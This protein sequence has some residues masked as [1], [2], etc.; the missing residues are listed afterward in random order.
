MP[1]IV[2]PKTDTTPCWW[3]ARPSS[4]WARSATIRA[5]GRTLLPKVWAAIDDLH[6]NTLEIPIYW[7]Q[8]EPEPGKF[9]TSIVD[10]I[11]KQAREHNVRLVLLWF[12]T[13]KNG[14]GHYIPLWAKK[15]AGD[16]H[17]H[18]GQSRTHRG[19]P[20]AS[21]RGVPCGPT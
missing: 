12:G 6:A 2:S 9:D 14:S 19:F 3:M 10:L 20:I 1:Q 7:E 17:P 5:R 8:F 21:G 13:W 18:H 4:C 16:L 15:P 11:I